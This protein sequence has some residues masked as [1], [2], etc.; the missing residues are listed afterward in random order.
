MY[1]ASACKF[2]KESQQKDKKL[3]YLHTFPFLL[4]EQMK[5]TTLNIK[6][7][8]NFIHEI[9]STDLQKETQGQTNRPR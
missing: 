9:Q 5:K 6:L 4:K 7:F 1:R 2:S 3:E 8:L